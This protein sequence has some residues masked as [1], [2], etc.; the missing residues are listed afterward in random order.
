MTICVLGLDPGPLTGV[1]VLS[2]ELRRLPPRFWP[3]D[4][5]L[6]EQW[7]AAEAEARL[8][9][10]LKARAGTWR[11]GG[12][13]AY[14]SGNI[15]SGQAHGGLT[16]RQVPLLM[17]VAREHG[18]RLGCVPAGTCKPWANRRRMVASGVWEKVPAKLVH[19]RSASQVAVYW[20]VRS[21]GIPDPL[22]RRLPIHNPRSKNP[23]WGGQA[24][25]PQQKAQTET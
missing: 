3:P 23:D 18:L 7:P 1:V 2:W 15:R 8:G 22:S 13:E 5:V 16:A 24:R 4:D 9:A 10:L 21:G 19:A 12:I 17:A 11:A 20:S 25:G 6:A 14:R